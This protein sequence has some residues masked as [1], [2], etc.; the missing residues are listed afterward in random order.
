MAGF[1]AVLA[2]LLIYIFPMGMTMVYSFLENSFS[3]APVG[4]DNYVYVWGKPSF[5]QAL[6][7]TASLTAVLE[8][9]LGDQKRTH[10]DD[11]P[12]LLLRLMKPGGM[13]RPRP[14]GPC[15]GPSV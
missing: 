14:D 3:K 9:W 6:Q 10:P 2:F 4:F 15:R 12:Q 13:P 5:Q 1:P 7:N 11:M 8:C